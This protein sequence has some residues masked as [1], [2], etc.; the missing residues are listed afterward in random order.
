MTTVPEAVKTGAPNCAGKGGTEK[1]G[2]DLSKPSSATSTRQLSV[3]GFRG[4]RSPLSL[5]AIG[6]GPQAPSLVA[7]AAAGQTTASVSTTGIV[8]NTLPILGREIFLRYIE[9]RISSA[10]E[11][12][13]LCRA[14]ARA[15]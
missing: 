3:A 12:I 4:A 10:I 13:D 6:Q 7:I 9:K 8:S 2:V 15:R 14:R 5:F 11:D 1:K